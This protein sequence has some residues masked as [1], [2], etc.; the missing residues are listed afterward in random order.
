MIKISF[1]I[2]CLLFSSIKNEEENCESFHHNRCTALA[3]THPDIEEYSVPEEFDDYA[4]QTPPRNDALG[5]Y[6]STYQDMRYLVGYAELQ[7]NRKQ[8]LCTIT[9]NTRVNPDLGTEGIDYY[10]L[11][12]FGDADEQEDNTYEVNSRDDSY[13]NGLS[14]SCRIIN[15]K[16][17]NEVVSL[18]LQDIYLLWDNVE[19]D[20][21]DEYYKNGQKGSIVELFG[22]SLEDVGEEC[23]FL[24]IAGYLGVKIFSPNE[25]LLNDANV[26]GGVLNPW[27]YGTQVV[28]YK[29][30]ARIGN[31]KQLKKIINRCRSYNVRVYAEVVINHMTGEGND[32]NVDHI[33]GGE[34]PCNH[35]GQ[36]TGSGFSPMFQNSFQNQNNYYTGKLPVTEYPAVP[37]F[38]SDFHCAKSIEDWDD[39]IELVYGYMVGLQDLN[40]EKVYVQKRIATFFVDMVSMGISGIEIANGRHIQ[41]SSFAKI[42]SYT[43]EYLG[44]RFPDDFFFIIIIEGIVMDIVFCEEEGLL[45]FGVSFTE[46]LKDEG[47]T[48]SDINQVKFWFKGNLAYSNYINKYLPLCDDEPQ[49]NSE[50][51]TVSLE[52][53]DDINKAHS[54]YNIYIKTKDKAE[55]KQI[56]IED[57]FLHPRYDY[58][59]RF[60]FSSFSLG[61]KAGIPDGKSEKSYCSTEACIEQTVD[62]PFKRAFNPHSVGYDCGDG[63]DNWV[64][65]EYSR[66]HRDIDVINAMRAWIFNTTTGTSPEPIT[67]EELYSRDLAKAE[68]DE[69]CLICNEE[70]KRLDKCIFCDSNKDYFPVMESGGAEEYYQCYKR[71]DKVERLYFSNR[72]KAFLSCYE[73]CRYCDEEGDAN[74]HK[75]TACDYNLMKRPGTKESATTFN[76]V[77]NCAYSYYYTE[78]GRFKCTNTPICPQDQPILIESKKKCIS[79]CKEESPNIYLY[80]GE[81]VEVCPSNT[82]PDTKNYLCKEREVSECTLGVKSETISSLYSISMINSF[83]KAYNDEY[84]Y[85]EKRVTKISNNHYNIYIFRD[86]TCPDQLGLG[87]TNVNPSSSSSSDIRNLD[88]EVNAGDSLGYCYKK[89]QESLQTEKDLIVVFFE[90][91]SKVFVE[92]GYLLYHPESGAQIDF[93]GICKDTT[94]VE[95][96]DITVDD[97]SAKFKYIYIKPPIQISEDGEEGP[98]SCEEGYAPLYRNQMI[99]YTNCRLINETY[100]GIFYDQTTKMFLP[101]NENCKS[102]TKEGSTL[103]NNCKECAV[104]YI[105]N[106]SDG[107]TINFNCVNECIY[108]YYFSSSGIYTCTSGPTC[109]LSYKIYI[110]EKNQCIDA[111]RKDDRY[112]Y[113]YNGNCVEKCPEGMIPDDNLICIEENIDKCSWSRKQTSLKNFEDSGGLDSLVS[114]YH[115]EFY[116][117]TKHVSEFNSDE[118]N[119]TIY[120]ESNCLL[121][122][123]LNFPYIDFG[124]CYQKVQNESGIDTDLIVVLLKKL[125]T[126]TGRTSSSYSLYNPK[127]GLKLDAA[128]ICKDEEIVVEENVLDILEESGIDYES[129]VFLTG[130]NIDVFDSSGAFYTDLCYEFDSPVDRD[131]T[132]ED[133]L[134]VFYPNV[135]LCDPGCQSKGVNLTTMKAICSCTFSDIS[136]AGLVS[137]IEYLNEIFEIISSSNIMVLKCMKYMFKRFSSSVGGYLMIFCIIIVAI[138]GLVFYCRDLEKMKKYIINKTT[139]YINYLNEIAPEEDKMANIIIKSVD[140]KEKPDDSMV[141]DSKNSD[142]KSSESKPKNQNKQNIKNN[143]IDFKEQND[144]SMK[145]KGDILN[146][147]KINSSKEVLNNPSNLNKLKAINKDFDMYKGPLES[148]QKEDFK[149][150]LAPSV[151][152]QEF[153]DIILEDKR[154]FQEVFCDAI[155]DKQLLVNT[156]SVQDNFRP[157]SLKFVLLILTFIMYFVVNGLFYGD[158]AVSEIYHI[159]G[160]DSFFGFF[161]R[162]ITRYIYSAVVGTI[163]GII[164]DLFFVDEKKMKSIFNREKKNIVNLKVE[165]T[166]LTKGITTRYIAFVIFVIILFILLMF[167]LLCFNYVYPHTQGEWVKSSIFLIIIMQILSVVVAFLQAGLRFVGFALRSEKIFRFSKFFD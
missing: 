102:C 121:E 93:E 34:P 144:S 126:K 115:E 70:S 79:S 140:E 28:S 55:H 160:E 139:T 142:S 10:I 107:R 20:L 94:I 35:W 48:D 98:T 133:R 163:I 19:I 149:L 8:N 76:C 125:D 111:C 59:I 129:I 132:L 105:K 141:S 96:D 47:F 109:P 165:I 73:T 124:S 77:T 68:C 24:G 159:E 100:D 151:D 162:S 62:V 63:E 134:E 1:I 153:E 50:R 156:F 30:D 49:V 143:K 135:S 161:P 13:P 146:L 131:I 26:E 17:S 106:P 52:Y 112:F 118:Y 61:D 22:W 71:T 87:I 92:K 158:D 4:F 154:S 103:E 80:N 23:E 7:Y 150:Y 36:K 123:K 33:N 29:Y 89:V 16:T 113:T 56:L 41:T 91:T 11:Y 110:P 164:I 31:Q 39:P 67:K 83:V 101:C 155:N 57:L 108:A 99:D 130:Q 25:H 90:D 116:Y 6:L 38:P 18:K 3:E 145:K 81:C 167:Y 40:T 148:S 78:S 95:K 157:F 104:G 60:V 166:K 72:E 84:F 45:D 14:L 120:I 58:S 43:K 74:D 46:Q 2:L 117:T 137:D 66:V 51:W 44:G 5:N 128:T 9:F 127:N 75:C 15:R 54:D 122:L 147:N 32:M 53:S 119:I 42:F 37:Y 88:E 85:N 138:C 65:P 86:V 152:D 136:N 69:K 114:S 64:Q 97:E 12:T 27:W 82:V 21:P